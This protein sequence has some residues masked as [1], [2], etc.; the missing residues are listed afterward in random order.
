[1]LPL[2]QVGKDKTSYEQLYISLYGTVYLA[3]SLL[4]S[5]TGCITALLQQAI[6]QALCHTQQVLGYAASCYS[7]Q[8]LFASH[9]TSVLWHFGIDRTALALPYTLLIQT[10]ATEACQRGQSHA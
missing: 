7:T 5:I 8:C 9:A 2:H 3:T 6:E 4:V 1:M 10:K